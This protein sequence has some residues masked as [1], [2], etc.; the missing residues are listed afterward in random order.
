MLLRIEYGGYS[1][2][3]LLKSIAIYV[4]INIVEFTWLNF[5]EDLIKFPFFKMDHE[6]LCIISSYSSTGLI[7][8]Y[9]NAI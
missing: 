1:F 4:N 5:I 9:L 7:V 2:S 8:C 6:Y 3:F